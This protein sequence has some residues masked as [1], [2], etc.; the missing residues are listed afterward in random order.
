VIWAV[1]TALDWY[2]DPK[3]WQ[4]LIQNAMAQDFSWPLQ[5][6]KY[7]SLYQELLGR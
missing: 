5:I 7:E 3:S 2:G 1:G 4:P 6:R